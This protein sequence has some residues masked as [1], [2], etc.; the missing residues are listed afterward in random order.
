M[1]THNFGNLERELV[2]AFRK[3]PPK[4]R[5]NITRNKLLEKGW[6][7]FEVEM[8]PR[9]ASVI[10]GTLM[11]LSKDLTMAILYR[12][13]KILNEFDVSETASIIIGKVILDV[14]SRHLRRIWEYHGQKYFN[15]LEDGETS[16]EEA[17][18]IVMANT[19]I[20]PIQRDIYKL[21]IT[22]D[23]VR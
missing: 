2:T 15:A 3:V 11:D 7:K 23:V 22:G 8:F 1:I 9:M 19:F 16:R 4:V 12:Y 17:S 13:G 6:S 10:H 18:N 21:Y 5:D 14:I 20:S